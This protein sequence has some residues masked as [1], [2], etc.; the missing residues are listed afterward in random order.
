MTDFSTVVPLKQYVFLFNFVVNYLV[1]KIIRM[2]GYIDF[3]MLISKGV[4]PFY[5]ILYVNFGM[6]V[7]G[8]KIKAIL[9]KPVGPSVG[10]CC[11]FILLP[12]V[13]ISN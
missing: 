9:K 2:T 11:N 3:N 4:I 12:L 5:M 10:F 13:R 7:D 6:A 1:H 8:Q